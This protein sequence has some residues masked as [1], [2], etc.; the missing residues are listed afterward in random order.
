MNA[1][2][3]RLS[4]NERRLINREIKLQVHEIAEENFANTIATFM[5]TL[6]LYSGWG[7]KKLKDFYIKFDELHKELLDWYQLPT[8][9]DGWLCKIKLKEIGVDIDEWIRED[10]IRAEKAKEMGGSE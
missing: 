4:A 2:K 3:N 1:M 6:H 8:T 10:T 9:D 5:Y 7:K